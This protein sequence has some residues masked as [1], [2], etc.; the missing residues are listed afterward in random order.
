[1]KKILLFFLFVSCLSGMNRADL[2]KKFEELIKV[3]ETID[4]NKINVLND[5][6]Y[7]ER[8]KSDDGGV[9]TFTL[10]AIVDK[11]VK[12]N[13]Q[14]YEINDHIAAGYKVVSVKKESVGISNQSNYLEL[15]LKDN[16]NVKINVK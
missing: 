10:F 11:R 6:F 8:V 5:P 14:W 1:M 9:I 3:R 15:N 12:I 2:D 7:K 4:S 13:Q 16:K